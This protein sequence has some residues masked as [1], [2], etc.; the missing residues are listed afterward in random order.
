[1]KKYLV[2][3]VIFLSLIACADAMDLNESVNFALKNNPTVIAAQKKAAAARARYNQAISAF[4]PTVNLSGDY[5]KAYSSPQTI[6]LNS[7]GTAQNVKIGLDETATVTG[8]KADLSQPIFVSALFPS[9]GIA[10]K[11][12]E[13][14]SENYNQT[15][16]EYTFNVNQAYFGV[17]RAIKLEKLLEDALTMTT[18]HRKQVE[19][20]LKA[21]MATKA[22]LLR[23]KVKEANSNV[24]LIQSRYAIAVANDTFNNV[25][26]R[27]MS[28]LVDLKDLGFTGKVDNTPEYASLLQ[29]AY[30]TRPDWKMYLLQT[31][32]SE[33]Q[34]RLSQ[35]EYLPDITLLADTGNR[36]TKFSS[37]NNDVNSWKVAGMG[38]WKIFDSL[39]RENRVRE[40]AENLEAQRASLQQIKNNIALEVHTAYLG[41]KNALDTVVATQQEVDSAQEG[42]NVATARY[43]AG[44]GTNVDV[45]DAQVDLTQASTDHLDALFNVEITKAQINKVVGKAVL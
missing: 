43:N 17:L 12:Y 28:Q 39:G 36:L 44:M 7:G 33:E 1:M 9:Y 5:D 29:L 42:F 14:A 41:L 20:M 15:A 13:S 3:P 26:G 45:M 8:I 11:G 38:S 37:F 4:F 16:I 34:L 18:A 40:A 22:D 24:D 19:A 27:D 25:L 6:H 21:G 30:K 32:I 23:S 2:M 31:G 10:K 35:S